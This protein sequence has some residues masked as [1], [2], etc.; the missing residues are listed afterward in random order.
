MKIERK[1]LTIILLSLFIFAGCKKDKKESSF[2]NYINYDGKMYELSKGIIENWGQWDADG[3][4]NLDLTLTSSGITLVEVSG[5]IDHA[6]G[7]GHGIYLE[8]FTNNASQLANGTYEY[9]YWSEEAGTF[10]YGWVSINYDAALDDAEI[11]QDIEGGTVT[12]N[13]SG[14]IYEITFNCTDE[15]GKSVTGYFKGTLKYY[16]YDMKKSTK[17]DKRRF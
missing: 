1:I 10:D 7:K 15:D 8:M 11:D 3:A 16:D 17:A 13:K 5:E 2:N 4:Y 12:I 9:D 14:D 6:E